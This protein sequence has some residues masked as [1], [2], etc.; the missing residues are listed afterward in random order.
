MVVTRTGGIKRTLYGSTA[1]SP[2]KYNVPFFCKK[3]LP[4]YFYWGHN[5]LS[6]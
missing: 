4:F 3:G 6:L 5:T 1:T 2:S